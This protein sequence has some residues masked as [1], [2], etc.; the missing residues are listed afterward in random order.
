[1]L[2]AARTSVRAG[3]SH[4]TL[5]LLNHFLARVRMHARLFRQSSGLTPETP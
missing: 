5:Y 3:D 2:G 1:M 4:Q